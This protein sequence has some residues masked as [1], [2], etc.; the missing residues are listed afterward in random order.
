MPRRG[1]HELPMAGSKPRAPSNSSSTSASSPRKP[2]SFFGLRRYSSRDD[3][4]DSD[5]VL[6]VSYALACSLF[7]TTNKHFQQGGDGDKIVSSIFSLPVVE[8]TTRGSNGSMPS[9]DPFLFASHDK[10]YLRLLDHTKRIR[11]VSQEPKKVDN[12]WEIYEKSRNECYQI[13][14]SL[15]NKSRKCTPKIWS[16]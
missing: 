1:L 14:K 11:K 2:P 6:E 12:A 5:K 9:P 7:T 10:E 13:C 4:R 15:F 16:P 8:S 3:R